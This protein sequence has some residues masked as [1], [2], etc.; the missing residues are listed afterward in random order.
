MGG[1]QSANAGTPNHHGN[2]GAF[3]QM[4]IVALDVNE[5]SPKAAP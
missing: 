4:G 5:L 1:L 3:E 2:G